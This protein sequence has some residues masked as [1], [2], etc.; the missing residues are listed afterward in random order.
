M[1]SSTL[2]IA[3]HAF[4]SS[5]ADYRFEPLF[6]P[7]CGAR[8]S[9]HQP[10]QGAPQRLLVTCSCERGGAWYTVVPAADD[11]GVYLIRI[12]PSE[13]MQEAL[14]RRATKSTGRESS[15]RRNGRELH[16]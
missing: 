1:I 15:G 4:L 9:V 6:C 16:G 3:L 5:S 7:G 12:P 8:L 14:A 11:D 10:E 2:E 13:E